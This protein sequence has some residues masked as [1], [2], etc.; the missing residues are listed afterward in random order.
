MSGTTTAKEQRAREVQSDHRKQA[1]EA[2][3]RLDAAQPEV[4]SNQGWRTFGVGTT[5]IREETDFRYHLMPSTGLNANGLAALRLTL[6]TL[7]STR[8]TPRWLALPAG[9]LFAD[10]PEASVEAAAE[11]QASRLL[12]DDPEIPNLLADLGRHGLLGVFLG[13]DGTRTFEVGSRYVY[14]QVPVLVRVDGR[15]PKPDAL[16]RRSDLLD[17][18]RM[19][20]PA[21][22]RLVDDGTCADALPVYVAY[23]GEI[24]RTGEHGRVRGFGRG[25]SALFGRLNQPV[26]KVLDLAHLFRNPKWAVRPRMNRLSGLPYFV[27]RTCGNASG[28]DRLAA[29]VFASAFLAGRTLACSLNELRNARPTLSLATDKASRAGN[30][31]G[32]EVCV[33]PDELALARDPD[34]GDIRLAVHLFGELD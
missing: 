25:A 27:T 24:G 18:T 17:R 20:P 19:P 5:M 16:A 14:H 13:M 30:L 9:L 3:E 11:A 22:H 28:H 2:A 31:C 1:D 7:Q 33:A 23:C 32:S 8:V 34:S 21:L 12:G 10:L 4:A 29:P 6:R 15:A 26:G